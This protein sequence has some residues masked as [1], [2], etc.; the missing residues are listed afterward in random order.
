MANA[1]VG[2]SKREV[3]RQKQDP[4]LAEI[5]HLYIWPQLTASALSS[6]ETWGCIAPGAKAQ[7]TGELLKGCP[8]QCPGAAG[9]SQRVMPG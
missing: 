9:W 8:A 5:T 7:A 6:V 2:G 4:E 3:S 1:V